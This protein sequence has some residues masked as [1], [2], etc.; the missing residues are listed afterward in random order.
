MV[1]SSEEKK[2][3][4]KSLGHDHGPCLPH[5]FGQGYGRVQEILLR[6]DAVLQLEHFSSQ[7]GEDDAQELLRPHHRSRDEKIL[8]KSSELITHERFQSHRFPSERLSNFTKVM[9][10]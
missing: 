5:S 9:S 10:R 1:Q 3:S 4:S 6:E 7:M 8:V 2:P